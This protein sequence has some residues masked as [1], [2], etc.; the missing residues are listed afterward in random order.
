MGQHCKFGLPLYSVFEKVKDFDG[1]IEAGFYYINT[2]NFFPIK[3]SGPLR[4]IMHTNV[5]LL[6]RVIYY[7][8]TKPVLF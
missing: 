2:D 5:K 3:G 4:Y 6:K 1:D 8:N 7:N